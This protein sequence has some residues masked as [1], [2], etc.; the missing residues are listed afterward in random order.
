M[1]SFRFGFDFSPTLIRQL[2]DRPSRAATRV[3]SKTGF[4]KLHRTARASLISLRRLSQPKSETHVDSSTRSKQLEWVLRVSILAAS[5]AT[6]ASFAD[7]KQPAK[8]VVPKTEYGQPDLRG[9]W[10]FS[11]NT[12]FERPAKYKDREF[13]TPEE[14]AEQHKQIQGRSLW[15]SIV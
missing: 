12:P 6:S 9:V 2:S 11:S 1:L 15:S 5:L 10:N 3:D 7:A 8:Y 13:M 4:A 14:A